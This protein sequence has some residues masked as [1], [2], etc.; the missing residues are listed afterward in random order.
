MVLLDGALAS[1]V[2]WQVGS[3]ATFQAGSEVVG[4]VM[5]Y[6]SI[7]VLSKA[8]ING[9]LFAL[10]GAVTLIE[11]MIEFPHPASITFRLLTVVDPTPTV[12]LGE[13][14]SFTVLA[15]T[16]VTNVVS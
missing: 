9:R 2:F 12:M 15:G 3:S 6:A 10:N 5:A 7:A 8:I 13:S 14:E 1:D 16:T 4:T 11:N